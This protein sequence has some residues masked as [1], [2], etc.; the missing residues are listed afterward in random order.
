MQYAATTFFDQTGSL[1]IFFNNIKLAI[2]KG[3]QSLFLLSA[4]ENNFDVTQVNNFLQTLSVPV[5]GGIFPQIIYETNSVNRGSI[6]CGAS[7]VPQIEQVCGLSDQNADYASAIAKFA[8]TLKKNPSIMLFVDGNSKF[9]AKFIEKAYRYLGGNINYFGG[10]AGSLTLQS[11]PCIYTNKGLLQNC[12][13]LIGFNKR[14]LVGV[15]H[16]WEKFAGPFVI[17]ES[18]HNIIKMIDYQPAFAVYQKII[19][20]NDPTIKFNATNFFDIAKFYPLGIEMLDGSFLVRDPIAVNN[21]EVICVAEVP[22]NSVVYILHGDKPKLI[23]AAAKAIASLKFCEQPIVDIECPI[24]VFDC[25]SR[26]LILDQQITEELQQLK[27]GITCKQAKVMG[28][29]TIGEIANYGALPL[30]FFNKT[31]VI[32][33]FLRN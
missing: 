31:L 21:N 24:L 7:F 14:S 19:E 12:A 26:C 25:I 13:Q 29:A 16:G 22:E 23:A 3:A 11:K 15:E 30:E 8:P 32:S 10:G 28:A 1:E 2:G 33:T 4:D 18:E 6:V 17:T 9:I 5:F 27:N 20:E